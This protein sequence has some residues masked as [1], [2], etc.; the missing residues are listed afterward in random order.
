M[1]SDADQ[2]ALWEQLRYFSSS[3]QDER[4]AE[5]CR[6]L[7]SQDPENDYLHYK[8]SESLRGI[9]QLDEAEKHIQ[10][11]L[12]YRPD[13]S[14]Y[15]AE[16]GAMLM[17]AGKNGRA[18]DQVRKAIHL[19]PENLWAWSLLGHLCVSFEDFVQARH[20]VERLRQS[21]GYQ[22]LADRLEASIYSRDET[23]TAVPFE[24][25]K[26]AYERMLANNP[27]DDSAHFG[28]GALY[29]D[30]KKDWDQAEKHFRKAIELDPEDKGYQK[31]LIRVLRRKDPVLK[32]LWLPFAPIRWLIN[33]VNW[34]WEKKWPLI[35]M[36]F[37]FK[38]VIVAGLF[39]A[40]IFFVFFWPIAKAYEYLRLADFHKKAG[41]L[42]L[43]SGPM[44]R[45]HQSPFALRM[46]LF[47]AFILFFWLALAAMFYFEATST[48]VAVVVPSFF[49][50]GFLAV[51]GFGWGSLIT[52]SVR[53]ASRKRKNQKL[54]S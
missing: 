38:Y 18:D 33:L 48:I 42:R 17:L 37:L 40:L 30:D 12:K 3:N 25:R 51:V 7:L 44:A 54:Q 29:F 24:Q 43:Y 4:A 22:E 21:D 41:M 15:H 20:C 26:A 52:S 13:N 47:C 9:G 31:T 1:P 19:D 34:T 6:E 16:Y 36:I 11:A 23:R 5:V 39:L 28:L 35:F 32:L 2:D 46:G 49:V 8:L 10:I 27:E 50:L 45:L 14:G 53:K